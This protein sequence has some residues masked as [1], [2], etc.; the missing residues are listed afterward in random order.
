MSGHM[1]YPMNIMQLFMDMEEM[2]GVEYQKSLDN[3]KVILDK[4]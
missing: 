1:D 4:K 3:L 2:I